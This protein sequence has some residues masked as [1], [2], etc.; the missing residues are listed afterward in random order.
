MILVSKEEDIERIIKY[1]KKNKLKSKKNIA[2]I[3]FQKI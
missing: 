2:F 1:L 3:R